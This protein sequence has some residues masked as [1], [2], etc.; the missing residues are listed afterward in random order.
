MPPSISRGAASAGSA[1]AVRRK[2]R[3]AGRRPLRGHGAARGAVA[4]ACGAAL[5]DAGARVAGSAVGR[6]PAAVLLATAEVSGGPGLGAAARPSLSPSPDALSR[7]PEDEALLR[8]LCGRRGAG[9]EA[10][11]ACF[12]RQ[13][14][15]A[16]FH[17]GDFAAAAALYSKVGRAALSLPPSRPGPAL[18]AVP[19]PAGRVARG[20]RWPRA[21][22]VLRQPLGR[23]LPSAAPTGEPAAGCAGGADGCVF[24]L[25]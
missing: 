11:A 8:A 5:G 21:A 24:P 9:K 18:T 12:Y 1:G 2:Y 10:A 22:P 15:N 6:G 20:A 4:G 25:P 23:A 13:A 7:R 3:S 14:G 19:L 17:R 16:R